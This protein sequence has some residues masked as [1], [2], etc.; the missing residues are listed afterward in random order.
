MRRSSPNALKARLRN[1]GPFY[2][3]CD[4]RYGHD[5]LDRAI[6]MDKVEL[7]HSMVVDYFQSLT[8]ESGYKTR[9][10][11]QW[12]IAKGFVKYIALMSPLNDAWQLMLAAIEEMGDIREPAD[13]QVRYVR[14]LPRIVLANLLEVA[15]PENGENPFKNDRTKRRNWLIVKLLLTCGLRRG[16]LLL[17]DVDSIKQDVEANGQTSYWLDVT[18]TEQED[19]RYS[20]PSI[21]T[22]E[23]HRQ[24]PISDS[25]ADMILHYVSEVRVSDDRHAFLFTAESG[26]P[27][28]SES[29]NSFFVKMSKSL[30]DHAC[31]RFREVTGGKLHVSPHDLRHTC[32]TMRYIQYLEKEGDRELAMQRM[33]A[34]FGWS[35]KSEMP[36]IYARA[37][38][39]EDLSGSWDEI[40][41][42]R[43]AEIRGI[44]K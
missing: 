14:A 25:I 21:K 26:S 42:Q 41:D 13:G 30:T 3:M 27:L 8:D 28:S 34:Y 6:G 2:E 37:A 18:T 40:F 5:A 9:A 23:S 12:G 15:D 29:I 20:K 22:K 39:N 44:A 7:V 16:E 43:I 11:T 38:I 24:I 10:V 36:D 35:P 1:L 32:A 19:Y 4:I 33:R 31:A 17:L